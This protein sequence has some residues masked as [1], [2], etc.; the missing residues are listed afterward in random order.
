MADEFILIGIGA[1][2][3]FSIAAGAGVLH[4]GTII[5]RFPNPLERERK[6]GLASPVEATRLTVVLCWGLFILGSALLLQAGRLTFIG[7]IVALFAEVLFL[8]TALAFSF[9]VLHAMKSASGKITVASDIGDLEA[10]IM[11][12][13][14]AT[15]IS[16]GVLLARLTSSDAASTGLEQ[17]TGSLKNQ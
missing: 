17:G 12:T 5:D 3:I 11:R 8:F 4:M 15:G 14:K 13:S 10:A 6:R 2:A 7:G 1:G 9:A 16:P